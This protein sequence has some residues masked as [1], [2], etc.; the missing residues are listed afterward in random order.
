DKALEKD[1]NLRYQHA[2]EIKADLQ[3]LKR[4]TDGERH[5]TVN[6]RTPQELNSA[7][8]GSLGAEQFASRGIA[9]SASPGDKWKWKG[10]LFMA[11][12]AVAVIAG[13]WYWRSHARVKLSDRDTIVVADFTN[14]TAEPVFDTTLRQGLTVLLEQS[15]FLSIVSDHQI[16]QTL[17]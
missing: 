1:R 11:A 7:G 17:R 12:L 6:A 14:S 8:N 10:L 3:R 2:S 9:V 15:P 13:G 4:D 16:Q 5:L